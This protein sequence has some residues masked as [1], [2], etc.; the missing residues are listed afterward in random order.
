M[1]FVAK[2]EMTT[3]WC[4]C[5]T[6]EIVVEKHEKGKH[7]DWNDWNGKIS[8]IFHSINNRH[9]YSDLQTCVWTCIVQIVNTLH[10]ITYS[11]Q[12]LDI[13][14]TALLAVRFAR[15][16][17]QPLNSL[18]T[19]ASRKHAPLDGTGAVLQILALFKSTIF[20]LPKDWLKMKQWWITNSTLVHIIIQYSDSKEAHKWHRATK[21]C[22]KSEWKRKFKAIEKTLFITKICITS[23]TQ[24]GTVKSGLWT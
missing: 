9:L 19:W 14:I 15:L 7:T 17:L 6:W 3:G 11:L 23:A 5:L 10:C 18:T 13:L 16:P 20:L 2:P 22:T 21:Q 8:F 24:L 4:S 1:L 12:C